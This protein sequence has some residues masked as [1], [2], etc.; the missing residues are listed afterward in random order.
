MPPLGDDAGHLLSSEVLFRRSGLIVQPWRDW[1]SSQHPEWWIAHNGVKHDRSNNCKAANIKNVAYAVAGLFAALLLY[2][3]RSGVR[4]VSPAP[5][6]LRIS[7]RLG[8][9]CMSPEG[10][11]ISLRD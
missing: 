4:A 10:A 8:A 6:M 7:E 3:R 9:H 2:L 11:V 1:T 5:H